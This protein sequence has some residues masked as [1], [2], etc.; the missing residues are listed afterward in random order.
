[1]QTK[2]LVA[3]ASQSQI[4]TSQLWHNI[5]PTLF[6]KIG[7]TQVLLITSEDIQLY[8]NIVHYE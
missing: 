3:V 2:G 8:E 1:M 5:L 6:K 4:K 7:D